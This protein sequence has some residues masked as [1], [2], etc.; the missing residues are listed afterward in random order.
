MTDDPARGST[1][2]AAAGHPG[3]RWRTRL[4]LGAILAAFVA[5][6]LAFNVS[7]PMGESPDEPTHLQYMRYLREQKRLPV[8]TEPRHLGV[9]QAGHPPLYYLA[10]ALATAWLEPRAPLLVHNPHFTFN[11]ERPLAPNAFVHLDREQF[12][13]RLAPDALFVHVARLVSLLSGLV[14]IGATYALGR[15]V[16]PDRPY[17][18]WASAAFVAFLPGLAFFSGTFNNDTMA[19]A[20]SALVLLMSVRLVQG[21]DRRR[22][23]LLLGSVLGLGLMT[24]LTL[25]SMGAVAGLAIVGHA[26]RTRDWRAVPRCALWVGLPVLAIAGWWVV[27]NVMLYGLSDPLAWKRWTGSGS[28]LQRDTPLRS[29]L[30]AF[31]YIQWTSFWGSF[32]WTTIRFPQQA[33]RWLVGLLGL[34][35]AGWIVLV[36]RERHRLRGDTG[37]SLALLL[38]ALAL[39]YASN[40]RLAT[41]L[42]MVAAHGRYLYFLTPAIAVLAVTGLVSLAPRT[43][44]PAA[45]AALAF[46]LLALSAGALVA[47]VRPAYA[48]VPHAWAADRADSALPAGGPYV[49]GDRLALRGFALATERPRA[50]MPI[51]VTLSWEALP[52][53]WQP[54]PPRSESLYGFIHIVDADGEVVARRDFAP[55]GGR[56]PVIGWPPG[57]VFSETHRLDIASGAASGVGTVLVGWYPEDRP[58][59]RLAVRVGD[60]PVGDAAVAAMPYV[61]GRPASDLAPDAL[62]PRADRL[63]PGGEVTLSGARV[64]AQPRAGAIDVTLLWSVA[65]NPDPDTPEMTVFVHLIGPDGALAATA[66]APPDSGRFPTSYWQTGDEIVDE[67]RLPWPNGWP[68]DASFEVRVGMYDPATGARWPARDEA[69]RRWPDDAVG[70]SPT[71]AR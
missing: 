64:A 17:V 51:S 6:S 24:K 32:G 2:R 14:L 53:N 49:F 21:H 31:L 70:L 54:F 43:L 12:P 48:P 20:W 65:E 30:G 47:L 40:L 63:G 67:H 11:M 55:F 41:T 4:A 25:V 19:N 42:N 52:A 26:W 59:D 71:A 7:V 61:V 45:A 38:A 36:L 8:I 16:W 5:L 18:A 28:E 1:D 13:Y 69:G 44:R 50:G 56:L 10:G 9:V 23:L 68:E 3:R 35:A 62:P 29:E 66:D 46:F 22:D 57:R 27:R 33:Y 37:W 15:R 39:G 34:S 60:V 58:D